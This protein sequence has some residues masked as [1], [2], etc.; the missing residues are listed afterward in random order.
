MRALYG[1]GG[2][3]P[4]FRDVP[5]P[6][7]GSGVAALVRPLAVALCDLDVAYIANLLP[8][9]EPYA[10]GHEFTAEVTAVG[11]DVAALRPGD[12]VSVPFQISCGHCDR[13]R[14]G[15]SLY[16]RSVPPLSTFGLAPFGGGDWG[17]AVAD[18][19]RVPYADAMCVPVPDGVD[20]L[21]IAAVSDN[22][23]DGYRCVAPYARAGDDV[24]VL[25]SASVG[26]YA[27]AVAQALAVNCTYVDDAPE[28]LAAAERLGATVVEAAPDGTGFGEFP[29]VAACVSTPDGLLSALRSTEPGGTCVSAGIHYFPVEPPLYD[30]YRRGI[31]FVTARASA[32]DD[33]PAVL[34]LIAQGRLAVADLTA[35]TATFADAPDVLS[36][37][38]PHKTVLTAD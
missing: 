15:R 3:A 29:T 30:L 34:R 7:L 9:G 20:P 8:T 19:V 2:G 21:G 31:T 5:P 37:A 36:G 11:A 24:L 14:G 26:L 28:R 16:C 13:C 1:G 10:V 18:L 6:E 27:V 23:V 22:A 4:H 25:G 35:R 12:V 32:R 33:M 17:G 38:L